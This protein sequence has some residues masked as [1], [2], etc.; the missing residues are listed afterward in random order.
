M[1]ISGTPIN[2][3]DTSTLEG[4]VFNLRATL[5]KKTEDWLKLSQFSRLSEGIS[6][7][8]I[9]PPPPVTKLHSLQSSASCVTDLTAL[10]LSGIELLCGQMVKTVHFSRK[11]SLKYA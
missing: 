1:A 9:R 4:A 5:K 6:F 8:V 3:I 2:C 11:K 10:K 7:K